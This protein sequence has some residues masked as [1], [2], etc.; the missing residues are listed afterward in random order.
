M[1]KRA[2]SFSELIKR[3]EYNRNKKRLKDAFKRIPKPA[4]VSIDDPDIPVDNSKR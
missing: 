2:K 4:K 1:T 3:I